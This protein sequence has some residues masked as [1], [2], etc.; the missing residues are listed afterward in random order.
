MNDLLKDKVVIVT[1][2]ASGIGRAIAIGAAT[3]G[4]RAVIVSDIT[5]QPREGGLPT[6][7]EIEALGVLSL[8]VRTDVSKRTDNDALVEAAARFGGVDVM[9]ANAGITLRSDGADVAE[10]DYRRLMAVNL[11]GTLFGAQAAARQMKAK[12]KTGSIV[13]M[14]AW[15]ASSVPA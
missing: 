3:H 11:D 2:A 6:T 5:D 14:A 4:A 15:V 9:V 8:F 12:G 1:G 10:E 13:L 7:S